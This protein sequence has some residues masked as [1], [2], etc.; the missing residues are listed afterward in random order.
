MWDMVRVA[1]AAVNARRCGCVLRVRELRTRP[2]A[3]ARRR[4]NNDFD[5]DHL[6]RGIDYAHSRGK[7][8]YVASNIAPHNA[9]LKTYLR[10]MAELVYKETGLFPHLNPGLMDAADFEVLRKVSISMGI[11]LESSSERLGEK[12]MPHYGSPDKVPARRIETMRLAGETAVPF[13]SGILI[14]I[15]ETRLE[16]VQSL[17]DLR[18]VQ[19]D[20]GNLQEII[21]QNF[22]AKP[23]TLMVDAPE[24]DLNELL[25]TIAVARIIFGQDMNVQAPPN[26]SPGVLPQIVDA[27][28]NDWGGV[29]PVTP[30]FVNPEA[31]WPHLT[32]LANET[33]AA[34]KHLHERLALY[35]AWARDVER[36]IDPQ[37]QPAVRQALDEHGLD[38]GR[39]A[40]VGA[41]SFLDGFAGI[42]GG[43]A[44]HCW[45][46][47]DPRAATA[48]L[49]R[50]YDHRHAG[51]RSH[52]VDGG[53]RG[54]GRQPDGGGKRTADAAPGLT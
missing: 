44:D 32:N 35:P 16:R 37:L 8:F 52:P 34:G 48:R 47:V 51:R 4:S 18:A 13:T 20:Y 46:D 9:K 39:L 12:G 49:S 22:R 24:P 31:P 23:D 36:W 25:W 38:A 30:D 11:M 53:V 10:D 17:L 14:G 26:L 29:S 2:T 6:Y 27:G 43:D 33:A 28:I 19:A 21:I 45:Q 41:A 5:L 3:Q 50:I 40:L 15:G 54:P 7:A 1:A 42:I